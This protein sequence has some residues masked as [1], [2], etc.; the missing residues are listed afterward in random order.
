MKGR[1]FR[2]QP[3]KN[4]TNLI[5]INELCQFCASTAKPVG[6]SRCYTLLCEDCIDYLKGKPVC[7]F[8]HDE[9]E[10][11]KRLAKILMFSVGATSR[12]VELPTQSPAQRV[13][14]RRSNLRLRATRRE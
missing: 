4:N 10:N 11:P 3:E 1:K 2:R 7:L 13:T 12:P 9:L 5:V 14:T 6:C 8:C